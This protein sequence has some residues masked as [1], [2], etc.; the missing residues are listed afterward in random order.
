MAALQQ[1]LDRIDGADVPGDGNGAP[2]VT[3]L[4][5]A[6]LAE[7]TSRRHLMTKGAALAVLDSTARI[8]DSR[9]GT[10]PP[11]GMKTKFQSGF[12]RALAATGNSSGE[13]PPALG[14][15]VAP[16]VLPCST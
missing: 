7:P 5:L 14:A 4:E 3:P 8:Y 13:R 9:P 2:P 10:R 16:M 11:I 6:V 1:R 15:V 12:V